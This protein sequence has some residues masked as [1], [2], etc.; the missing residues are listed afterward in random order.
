MSDAPIRV[1]THLS[2][3]SPSPCPLSIASFIALTTGF[4]RA[5]TL[6]P[7]LKG[8]TVSTT[9]RSL[10]ACALLEVRFSGQCNFCRFIVARPC[11][12]FT[13]SA[14]K[15]MTSR[16]GG[17]SRS[18]KHKLLSNWRTE[19]ALLYAGQPRHV[20]THALS[21][22]ASAYGL[23]CEDFMAVIDG[24]E[25]DAR[26]DI[27]APSLIELDLYCE[28][29]AVAV[30]RLSVRIFGEETP[31]GERVAAE[32]GRALQLTNICATSSKMPGGIG[33]ICLASCCIRTAFFRS[34]RAGCWHSQR[35]PMSAAIW[36]C[37]PKGITRLPPTQSPLVPAA[38]CAQPR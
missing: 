18:L 22:A 23:R 9:T 31:A 5:H 26:A 10:C 30:G 25:M 11:T 7:R 27:R 24:M 13:R 33:C 1:I 32:L 19:I 12:P 34:P 17:A 20:I 37:S 14:V 29:V 28:R 15:S 6:P 8:N 2:L 36:P 3:Q 38:R 16:D 4:R 35:F 21:D